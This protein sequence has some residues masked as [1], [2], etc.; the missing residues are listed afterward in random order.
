[1]VICYIFPIFGTECLEK[2]VNPACQ[3]KRRLE[4]VTC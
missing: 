1:L 3:W 2:I 4:P